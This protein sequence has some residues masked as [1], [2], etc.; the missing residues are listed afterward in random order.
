M[1][2]PHAFPGHRLTESHPRL[3]VFELYRMRSLRTQG[4]IQKWSCDGLE[5]TIETGIDQIRINGDL[6]VCGSV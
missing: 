5:V 6:V 2:K 4:R 3:D 1:G